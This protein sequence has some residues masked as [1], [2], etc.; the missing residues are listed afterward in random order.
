M[1]AASKLDLPEIEEVVLSRQEKD[2]HSYHIII[3]TL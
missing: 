1:T 3:Y 2:D